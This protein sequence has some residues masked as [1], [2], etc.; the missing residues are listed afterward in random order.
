MRLQLVAAFLLTANLFA[1]PTS[2]DRYKYAPFLA[3]AKLWNQV[4]YLH[5]R[6]DG[7]STTWDS[8]LLAAIPKID[9][10]HSDQDLAIALDDMLQTLH[11]PCT[12]IIGGLPGKGQAVQSFDHETLV[13]QPGTGLFAGAL[14][15]SLMLRS[16]LARAN[17]VVWDLRGARL[18]PAQG[19]PGPRT[20]VLSGL[21][22]AHRQHSGYPTQE[23][24]DSGNYYSSVV[25]V[26]PSHAA[27]PKPDKSGPREVYLIDKNSAVPLK[28]IIEQIKGQS[29]IVSEDPP[30]ELQAGLTTVVPL[31]GTVA[32]E[33]RVGEL[34]YPDGTTG[35]APTRVV[36]NRGTEAIKAA[37]DVARSE[38]WGMPGARPKFEI[39]PAGFRDMSP[40]A[41]AY[42]SRE[43]RILAAIRIWGVLHYFHPYV[44]SMGDKWDDVFIEFLPKFA[45]AKDANE[46]HLAVAEMV[47]RSGDIHCIAISPLTAA[48]FGTASQPFEIRYI[49]DQFV[50]TELYQPGAAQVGDIIVKVDGKPVQELVAA[51]SSHMS[52]PTTLSL[53][54]QVGQLLLHTNPASATVV[55]VKQPGGAEREITLQPTQQNS[56]KY[57]PHRTGEPIRI[58]DGKFGYAD[59][60]R[61]DES[62]V[63]E[64]FEK[65]QNT[66]AIILDLRGFPKAA[67]PAIAARLGNRDQPV[68]VEVVR[69]IVAPGFSPNSDISYGHTSLAAPRASGSRYTGKTIVLMDEVAL[70]GAEESALFLKAAGDSVLM[71]RPPSG[72]FGADV[73]RFGVPGNIRIT[74]SGQGIELPGGRPLYPAGLQPDIPVSPTIAGIIA[75]RD[76]ILERA[77]AYLS[78]PDSHR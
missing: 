35:F 3:A 27:P 64:M 60:E 77:I 16:G 9:A 55:T 57:R 74:F 47:A 61:L 1:A 67:A 21:G 34:R 51:L 66:P 5:P 71:G 49:E 62:Q 50:I 32:A 2:S 12:R 38:A 42:P 36:L 76:E 31:L 6:L 58:L 59:L 23:G 69:N 41:A 53:M 22:Y 8:A 73:T 65:L 28:A 13:I 46:Y 72:A 14:G 75:G 30:E 63:D 68:A 25:I 26:E 10:V 43:L 33:I 48:F 45:D 44:S 78:T 52:A 4:R 29:A 11:D 54:T 19:R 20:L 18:A 7:D 24:S 39:I 56:Q 17:N 40:G 15:P 37:A 70:S